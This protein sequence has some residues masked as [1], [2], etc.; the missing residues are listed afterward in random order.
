VRP[1]FW[2]ALWPRRRDAGG[3]DT[4][5]PAGGGDGEPGRDASAFAG[6]RAEMDGA[7]PG[8]EGDRDGTGTGVE[9]DRDG[10]GTGLL[11]R[12][13][14]EA[15]AV[16]L[17]PTMP[18]VPGWFDGKNLARF[19][20]AP[21]EWM[22]ENAFRRR[23]GEKLPDA[24]FRYHLSRIVYGDAVELPPLPWSTAKILELSRTPGSGIADYAKVVEQDPVLTRDVLFAARSPLMGARGQTPSVAQALVR[25]GVREVERLAL[26]QAFR[27]QHFRI[28]GRGDIVTRIGRHGFAAAIAAQAVAQRTGA[29]TELAYLGGLYHDI[30]KMAILGHIAAVQRLLVRTA[31]V[32]FIEAAFDAFHVPAG[33]MI[34]RAWDLPAA[35]ARAVALHHDERAAD[36]ALERAVY[37]GDRI[38]HA[39]VQQMD[40]SRI[41]AEEDPVFAATGLGTRDLGELLGETAQEIASGLAFAP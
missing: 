40:A 36:G 38:A 2:N 35:V 23:D 7:G 39:A 11:G 26:M 25:S 12:P 16:P 3:R 29:P 24:V 10:A 21:D 19:R 32:R 1:S 14:G 31:H 9:G 33:E 27:S 22:L 20:G 28:R 18:S 17:F 6:A 30:G 41:F 8:V 4:G 37:L 34:C 15:A 5:V 13:G